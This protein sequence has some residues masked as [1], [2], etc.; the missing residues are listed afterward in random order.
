MPKQTRLE[1]R[2]ERLCADRGIRMTGQRR[3]I[4]HGT[5]VWSLAVSPDGNII[6]A[7]GGPLDPDQ[8]NSEEDFNFYLYDANTGERLM[9]FAGHTRAVRTLTFSPDGQH[10]ISGANDRQIIMW[11][12]DTGEEIRRYQG[13]EGDIYSTLYSPDKT[14]LLTAARDSA[15]Y[16]WDIESAEIPDDDKLVGPMI[17]NIC[18]NNIREYLRL[19]GV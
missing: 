16:L 3:I 14:M 1:S 8:A 10:I 2:L 6:A 12:V 7:G 19:D 15:I 13:H 5:E 11:D 9:T 18:F 4:E 17:R